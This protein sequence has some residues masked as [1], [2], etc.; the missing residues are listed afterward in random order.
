MFFARLAVAALSFGSFAKVFAAPIAVEGTNV[1]IPETLPTQRRA[2]LD[3][4]GSL[5]TIVAQVDEIK[6]KIASVASNPAAAAVAGPEIAIMLTKVK[7]VISSFSNSLK[8][9]G[10]DDLTQLSTESAA[11]NMATLLTTTSYIVTTVQGLKTMKNVNNEVEDLKFVVV[12]LTV[13]ITNLIPTLVNVI[14]DVVL[15]VGGV[16][17][18]VVTTVKG[19][20]VVLVASGL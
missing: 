18:V 5:S 1:A 6:T 7:P 14:K 2:G 20:L 3:L 17:G 15:V 9:A 8:A 12:T 19:V 16:L 13:T 10:V 11:T 4:N